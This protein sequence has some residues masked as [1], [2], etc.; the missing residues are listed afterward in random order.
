M[1]SP[2][3]RLKRELHGQALVETALMIPFLL[4]LVFNTINFGFFFLV[5]L[6]ISAAPRSGVLYSILGGSTP[7]GISLPDP[8]PPGT[9]TSVSSLALADLT[10]AI[11][12]GAN[13][14]VQ[15]CTA[16]SGTTGSGTALLTACTQY[17]GSPSYTPDADPEAPSFVLNR[18]D[19]TYTFTPLLDQRLFNLILLATPTC[20]GSGGGVTCTFHRQVSM[21]AMN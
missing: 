7:I 5:A 16:R 3:S 10:G 11:P 20:T 19:I 14:P 1:V 17:N 2:Y 18:V 21:R 12:D 6:N 13:A 15:V 9:Q 8:G 4:W